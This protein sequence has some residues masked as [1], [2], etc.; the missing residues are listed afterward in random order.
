M[1]YIK[2]NMARFLIVFLEI[3]ISISLNS[4]LQAPKDEV[5]RQIFA[6]YQDTA[7]VQE[8]HDAYLISNKKEDNEVRSITV[9]K[10]S[11]VW[12]ATASGI[13]RKGVGTRIWEPV[14]SG[15]ERGP[16][17]SVAANPDGAVLMGTWN[18]IYRFF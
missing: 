10:E 7:F 9:D 3:I 13:F 1:S 18:G 8:S 12:I 11:N 16:A 15:E 5:A 17:Y 2:L 14:I 6:A 4:C